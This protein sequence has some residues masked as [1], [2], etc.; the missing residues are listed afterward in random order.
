MQVITK[1]SILSLLFLTSCV[2][3][4]DKYPPDVSFNTSSYFV[5]TRIVILNV[6]EGIPL[7]S[8]QKV[9][10][11]L[12]YTENM[13]AP[14]HVHFLPYSWVELAYDDGYTME[15]YKDDA[16]NHPDQMSI[17]YTIPTDDYTATLS[18]YG[19]FSK[20]PYP[21]GI[22][23]FGNYPSYV[24]AHE[25]GHHLGELRHT[26][27]PSINGD[28][29]VKD[30]KHSQ[31]DCNVMNPEKWCNESYVYITRGQLKRFEF[32]LKYSRANYLVK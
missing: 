2:G 7:V 14:I 6:F 27:D 16:K 24:L 29:G 15:T 10:K 31:H 22:V 20:S 8:E 13:L 4:S 28:D 26:N 19:E 3:N 1:G 17:Y 32:Y 11:D 23:I 21:F 9:L 5:R 12:K 18:G 25:I 30:T